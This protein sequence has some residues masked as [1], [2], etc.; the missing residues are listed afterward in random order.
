MVGTFNYAIGAVVNAGQ[1]LFEVTNLS[2]VYVEAQLFAADADKLK[3]AT[4]FTVS[5][6][7]NDTA[8]FDAKLVSVAQSVNEENQAQRIIFQIVNPSAQFRIGE[9]INLRVYSNNVIRKAMIP[10]DAITEVNGKPAVFI[11]DKAEVYSISFISTGQTN[12][13]YTVI[14][15]GAEEGER[16]V[17]Q[18]VYQMKTMYLNQ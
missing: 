9:N 12:G 2:N 11:K 15:K 18:N 1:T 7:I 8:Q 16:I 13:K 6:V 5:P 17:T 10:S 3:S 14:S 4:K